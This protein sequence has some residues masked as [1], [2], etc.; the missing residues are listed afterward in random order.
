MRKL[1]APHLSYLNSTDCITFPIKPMFYLEKPNR[2][3]CTLHLHSGQ[4]W[5]KEVNAMSD[6]G[7]A[8]GAEASPTEEGI[9]HVRISCIKENL[10]SEFRHIV[11]FLFLFASLYLICTEATAG[12]NRCPMA[13][14][15]D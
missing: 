15:G 1:A 3:P 7:G 8:R 4:P 12:Q 5:D 11:L 13:Q 14:T 6:D 9:G 2:T 10:P